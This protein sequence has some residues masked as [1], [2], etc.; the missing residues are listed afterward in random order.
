MPRDIE[1][2]D[3]QPL[4]NNPYSSSSGGGQINTQTLFDKAYRIA[5]FGGSIYI[6]H[7][8]EVYAT[9][10]RS[11]K[12]QHEWFKVGLAASIAVLFVK[13]YVELFAGKIKKQTVN[14]KNFRQSTHAIMFLVL[15]ASISFHVAL[16]PAYEWQTLAI[17]TLFGYGVLLQFGL[18]VPTYVQNI[19][20]FVLMTFFIQEYV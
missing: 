7:T 3:T 6:L 2:T 9:V 16:W 4:V 1:S 12:V 5:V 15:L 18:L 17:M 11:P 14:Y 10:H 19:V 8:W 20:G 13:A